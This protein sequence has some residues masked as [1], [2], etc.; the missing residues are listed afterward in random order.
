[1]AMIRPVPAILWIGAADDVELALARRAAARLVNV[2]NAADVAAVVAM[3]PAAFVDRSPVA[4]VLAS[5]APD[6]WSLAECVAVSRRWPLA[7]LVS[8]AATLVEGRRRSGPPLPGVEEVAWHELGGRLAWWLD[9]RRR[10]IPGGLGMPV[11]AR[12]EERLVE[13]ASR[14][15]GFA[16]RGGPAV[17]IAAARAADLEGLADLV[18]ASGRPILRRTIGRPA[19]DEPAEI[20]VW[21]VSVLSSAELTWVGLLTANRPDLA[22]VLLD[23]FPRGD[24]AVAALR[25]GAAAVLARPVSLEALTGTLLAVEARQAAGVGSL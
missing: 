15:A 18:T 11:T 1:M 8:V 4:I 7:P 21:D 19:L 20:L 12:R 14:V 23:S 6:R 5:P 16:A 17:S 9:D 22:V 25:S 10:G 2:V 3:A 13:A 24:L